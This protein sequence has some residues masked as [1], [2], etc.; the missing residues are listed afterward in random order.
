MDDR[1]HC[2]IDSLIEVD[3]DGHD[4]VQDFCRENKT[5]ASYSVRSGW[6]L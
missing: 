1:I 3:D 5:F 4:G 6:E 2:S